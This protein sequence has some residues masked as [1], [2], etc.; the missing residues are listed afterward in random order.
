MSIAIIIRKIKRRFHTGQ[1]LA[2]KP[3]FFL[4]HL[5]TTTNYIQCNS[6]SSIMIYILY[7]KFSIIP[8]VSIKYINHSVKPFCQQKI[9]NKNMP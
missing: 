5:L 1:K 6:T 9:T 4:S 8:T 3:Q 2:K 7:V